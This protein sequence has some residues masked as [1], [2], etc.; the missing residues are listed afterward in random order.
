MDIKEVIKN[1]ANEYGVKDETICD[2][3]NKIIE[4]ISSHPEIDPDDMEKI[5][6][7]LERIISE[8][9][10]IESIRKGPLLHAYSLDETIERAIADEYGLGAL[11][12]EFSYYSRKNA[13]QGP[14]E[15][16]SYSGEALEETDLELLATAGS[17]YT[18]K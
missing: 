7:C 4:R 11:A 16:E 8:R 3:Y 10:S 17:L 9:R 18:V 2:Y 13:D 12:C 14:I 5:I 15:M 1:F 6:N